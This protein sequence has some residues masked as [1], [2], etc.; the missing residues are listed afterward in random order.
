MAEYGA[1]GMSL[2][3]LREVEA[4]KA[5]KARYCLLLDAKDWVA[6][7]E[8]FTDDA[9]IGGTI[10]LDGAHDGTYTPDAFVGAVIRT[11]A[12]W[13]TFHMAH[14]QLIE[15]SGEASARGLWSYTQ[16]GFGRT[17]GYYDERYVK[18]D[19]WRISAMR[20]TMV[21]PY[22]TSDPHLARNEATLLA[23]RALV[24]SWGRA[25]DSRGQ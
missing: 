24:E 20:I 2:D 11:L 19:G 22:A 16:S 9:I 1:D 10:P 12:P 14:P 25:A 21:Q 8:L 15:I 13:T 23:R 7:R 18:R 6:Y 17:S 5:L 3:Y 4:I